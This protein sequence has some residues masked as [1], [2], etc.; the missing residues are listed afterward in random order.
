MNISGDYSVTLFNSVGCD[1]IV[2]L[3]FTFNTVSTIDNNQNQKTLTKVTDILGRETNI[4]RNKFLF[5]K[6]NDGTVEKKIVL[7]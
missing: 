6:F 3:N 2:N 4:T 5:Y 1:S 7:Q